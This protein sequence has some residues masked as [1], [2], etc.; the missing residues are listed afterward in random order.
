MCYV[1]V[2]V[3]CVG[4]GCWCDFWWDVGGVGFVM[5]VFCCV[6]CVGGF[7]WVCFC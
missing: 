3:G 1:M 5:L 7:G 2:D 4:V 6:V